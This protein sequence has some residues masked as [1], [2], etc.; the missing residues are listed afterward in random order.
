MK[1]I[2][3]AHRL[4]ALHDRLLAANLA[5]VLQ[6]Q[7]NLRPLFL[8]YCDTDEHTIVVPQKGKYLFE[9]DMERLSSLALLIAILHG[10]GYDDGVCMEVG[11]AYGLHIPL[12]FITTDF[13][14]Y[15]FRSESRQ[16][17]FS[18]PLFDLLDAAGLRICDPLPFP[19]NLHMP[20]YQAFETSHTQT[21]QE[22]FR[23]AREKALQLISQEQQKKILSTSRQKQVYIEPSPYSTKSELL[24]LQSDIERLGWKCYIA[25]RFQQTITS[26]EEAARR[27]L[28]Q[29]RQSRILLLDG[30]GPEVPAGSAFFTGLGQVI[31]A[32]TLLYYT[33]TQT[34]HAAGREENARNLMLLYGCT[35]LASSIEQARELCLIW[36]SQQ[37]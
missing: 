1:T 21:L 17:L 14:S 3:I 6:Q 7:E 33:G 35:T 28:Q 20:R 22:L 25:Q 9:R 30:N 2:Y 5:Q 36:C 16:F 10:P 19:D 29:A 26:T 4:F 34:T 11:C 32:K 18:D 12:L 13:L 15:S 37:Q 24:H 27:D 31:Q 23:A 8:P